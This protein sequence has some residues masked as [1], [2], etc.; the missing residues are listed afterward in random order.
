[1]AETKCIDCDTKISAGSKACPRCGRLASKPSFWKSKKGRRVQIVLGVLGTL[2]ALQILVTLVNDHTAE[3][4]RNASQPAAAPSPLPT[5]PVTLR[6]AVTDERTQRRVAPLIWT[7]GEGSWYMA[8]AGGGDVKDISGFHRG[9]DTLLLFPHGRDRAAIAVPLQIS[10]SICGDA[11]VRDMTMILLKNRQVEIGG[12]VVGNK[13]VIY[14]TDPMPATSHP[15]G[16]WVS[17]TEVGD[18]WPLTVEGG[19][20]DCI[21][22]DEIVFRSGEKAYAVNG[23]ASDHKYA[24]IDPI[25]RRSPSIAGTRINIGPLLD[26]GLKVCR[27]AP[28]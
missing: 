25:W 8:F 28:R 21:A 2:V 6:I 5:S 22:G 24:R 3:E 4:A 26:R 18:P 16:E 12:P 13:D 7:K 10:D 1:M 27:R 19:W 14:S 11:C 20:L 23:T 9:V 15:P 17:K